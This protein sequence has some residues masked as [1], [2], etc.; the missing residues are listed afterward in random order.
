MK[1][2]CILLFTIMMFSGCQSFVTTSTQNTLSEKNTGWGFRR[3][4]NGPEFTQTQHDTMKKYKCIYREN[5]D[6]KVI[7]LTFDEGYENGYTG[8]IL[9]VLKEKNVKAAFFVTAPYV[10]ENPDLIGR[11]AREG[12]IIGN[13]TANHPSMPS[14][15]D[16]EK[17]K[18]ELIELDRLVY[19]VCRQHTRYLRPPKGE[20][21]EKTLFLT[22]D[23]GYTNVFWSDAYVDWNDNVTKAEAHDTVTKNFHPGEVLL[24]HA[25][26]K[27]NADALGDIIDT[28]RRRGFEFKSLDEYSF[29]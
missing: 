9:D 27:G 3:T 13:H 12:H 6:K 4:E 16:D 22:N 1:R 18:N 5:T 29:N 15:K 26:S 10:K 11:M 23:F 2:L 25:V 21:S 14:V 19:G 20:Y 7:Y 17:L 8:I 28:A 24:L